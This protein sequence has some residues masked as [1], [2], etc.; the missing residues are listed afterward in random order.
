MELN[1]YICTIPGVLVSTI[2]FPQKCRISPQVAGKKYYL[3]LRVVRV[4]YSRFL[5]EIMRFGGFLGYRKIV[6][7]LKA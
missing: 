4:A 2:D 5:T 1:E 6:N 3:D 7:I